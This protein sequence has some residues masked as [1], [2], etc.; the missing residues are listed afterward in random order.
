VVASLLVSVL[1]VGIRLNAAKEIVQLIERRKELRTNLSLLKK[2]LEG[3]ET[4]SWINDVE[5]D[6]KQREVTI[7]AIESG[8]S[9]SPF[10][11]SLIEE[12]L[13][14]FDR[15]DQSS[16][17][18]RKLK[19]S[20]T[21]ER[22]ETKLD[23]ATG[24][25]LGRATAKIRAT[26]QEILAYS[27]NFDGRHIQSDWNPATSVRSELLERVNAHHSIIF[28]RKKFWPLRQRTFLNSLVAKRLAEEPPTYV[29]VAMPIAGHAKIG[30]KDE[31]GAIRSENR[32]C[33]KLTEVAPGITKMEYV[34]SL[35]LK[36]SVSQ[37]FTNAIAIP[38][39]SHG[40]PFPS[41]LTLFV[42]WP[43][44]AQSVVPCD[45]FWV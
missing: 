19:H 8:R 16:G 31:M 26:P 24:L 22:S 34:N 10:E 4:A 43:N 39:Q 11:N 14:M 44:R 36:G 28:T 37:R 15:F 2:S 17:A 29:L 30:R 38:G 41:V 40:A 12:G 33:F 7:A 27:L 6:A 18:F 13:G 5:H 9:C 1:L 21:V 20:V 42:C 3:E 45:R 35:N 32:R 25:L 23:E